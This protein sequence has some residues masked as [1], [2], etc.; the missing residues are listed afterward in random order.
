MVDLMSIHS[1]GGDP[2]GLDGRATLA[3][4]FVIKKCL[5]LRK[6]CIKSCSLA[7]TFAP[8]R[9]AALEFGAM[10]MSE[11]ANWIALYICL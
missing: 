4:M 5:N 7:D 9:S 6:V 8:L 3:K 2:L 11:L 1:I 10:A